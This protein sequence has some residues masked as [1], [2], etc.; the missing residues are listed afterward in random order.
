MHA[1]RPLFNFYKDD[2]ESLVESYTYAEF[3]EKTRALARVLL[4]PHA[5][6]GHGMKRGGFAMLVYPPSLD[7]IV[8]FV[9][10]LRAGIIAVPVFP[11]DPNQVR[12]VLCNHFVLMINVNAGLVLC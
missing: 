5:L 12:W 1:D 4:A 3:E 7:F 11:P 10:C 6:G 2:G 9:A 8:A